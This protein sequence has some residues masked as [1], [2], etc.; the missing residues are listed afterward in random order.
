MLNGTDCFFR[1]GPNCDRYLETKKTEHKFVERNVEMRERNL[2]H[3]IWSG[4]NTIKHTERKK[5]N[6]NQIK[7]FWI[8]L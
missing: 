3:V 4:F 2:A 6:Y 7:P 1:A 8:D 5:P